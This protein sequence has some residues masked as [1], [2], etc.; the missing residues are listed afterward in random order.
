MSPNDAQAAAG[1]KIV[2][3]LKDGS[4]TKESL[5]KELNKRGN[6]VDELKTVD[7]KARWTR[8]VDLAVLAKAELQPE[9][10]KLGVDPVDPGIAPDDLLKEN[11]NRLAI[12]EQKIAN[13]VDDAIRMARRNLA[14]DPD[15]T[16]DMLKNLYTRVNDHADLSRPTR[17][18]LASR[19]QAALAVSATEAKTL[20]IKRLEQNIAATVAQSNLI[21]E[22][23]R[24]SFEDRV[25]AQFR[26]Y[27]NLMNQARFEENTKREIL[28]AMV[29][30][31]DEARLNGR[32]VP[33]AAKAMYD[34][35]LAALPLQTHNTLVR[36]REQ[37]WLSLMMGIEKAHIPYPDEPY[38]HFPP[39]VTWKALL[40]ARKDKYEVT[41]LPDDP[42]G[43]K[44][45]SDI[46]RL[47]QQPIE[48]KGL[49]E[50]VKLKTALE[51][52]SDKFGGKLP[53]LVDRDAFAADLAPMRRI[54][55]K[56][57]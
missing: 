30:I 49:H 28:L 10:K 41:S 40:K 22:Q 20:K 57:K 44:E 50:K 32:S 13:T 33:V 17:K 52:F 47:F 15:G 19:L 39:L 35:A 42:Q 14:S 43:R 38:I 9:P 25:N 55:T 31:Q 11:R 16:L 21:K 7:G 56:R 54:R 2:D 27:K 46:Y 29:N 24:K 5:R 8:G 53:I 45:A 1:I 6:K 36:K 23:E 34:I 12:E 51:F 4:L 48:T 26:V 3:R 18:A 37:N